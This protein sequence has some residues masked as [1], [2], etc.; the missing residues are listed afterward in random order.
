MNRTAAILPLLV[1]HVALAQVPG[2]EAVATNPP[3]AEAKA[4]PPRWSLGTGVGVG[5]G[6]FTYVGSLSAVGAAPAGAGGLGALGS[7]GGTITPSV[8]LERVFTPRFALGLGLDGTIAT[9]TVVAGASS[10]MGR[11]GL[12]VSPRFTLTSE[13]SPVAFTVYATAFASYSAADYVQSEAQTLWLGLLG[14]VALERRLVERVALRVQAQFLRVGFSRWWAATT[15]P[16]A[17]G[18]PTQQ[19][20][21]GSSFNAGFEPVPS[22]ELRLYL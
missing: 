12:G 16:A 21:V 15:V 18:S 22:V 14:G 5:F 3:L 17:D 20:S 9:T 1:T 10:L 19:P 7:L 2:P 11:V 6:G 13:Q 8:S 4:D